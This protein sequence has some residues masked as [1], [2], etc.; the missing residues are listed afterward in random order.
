MTGEKR[1][2]FGSVMSES[3]V[4]DSDGIHEFINVQ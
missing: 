1:L 2:T 4:S 3:A